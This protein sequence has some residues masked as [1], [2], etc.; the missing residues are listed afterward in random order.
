M[1][2]LSS[3]LGRQTWLV[4]GWC[5]LRF[6]LLRPMCLV[7]VPSSCIVLVCIIH[8]LP[9]PSFC[10]LSSHLKGFFIFN[11][12]IQ[13]FPVVGF[14]MG[15]GSLKQLQP[16]GDWKELWGWTPEFLPFILERTIVRGILD[17][18]WARGRAEEAA[19]SSRLENYCLVQGVESA[20]AG[21]GVSHGLGFSALISFSQR[22]REG[23]RLTAHPSVC[24]SCLI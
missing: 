16:K 23:K 21:L 14:I 17:G 15:K 11:L 24:L 20:G 7:S 3:E 4:Y 5:H 10:P 9:I 1:L 8:I 13:F 18:W 6:Y 22:L 19:P 2:G 12:L